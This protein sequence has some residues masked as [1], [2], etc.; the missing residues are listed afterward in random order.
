MTRMMSH[1]INHRRGQLARRTVRA[2]RLR[3][4]PLLSY[5]RVQRT[6]GEEERGASA[7]ASRDH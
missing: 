3:Q 5:A 1:V 6:R 7:A 2:T 4:I